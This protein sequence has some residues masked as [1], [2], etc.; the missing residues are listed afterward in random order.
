[1]KGKKTFWLATTSFLVLIILVSIIGIKHHE[2]VKAKEEQEEARKVALER[3]QSLEQNA[4]S[5]VNRLFA[6]DKQLMLND[7]YSKDL[8]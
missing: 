4:R 3:E 5:A 6:S 7:N 2:T 1:M 8:K